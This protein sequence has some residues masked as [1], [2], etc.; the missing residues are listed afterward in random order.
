MKR[1]LTTTVLVTLL[2][3][4]M[5]FAQMGPGG[6]GRGAR[7]YD[8]ATVT[9]VKGT[10]EEVTQPTGKMGRMGT[11]LML[12]SEQGT[13]DVHVGPSSYIASQQF[14]FAKG[15]TIEVVGSKVK[16]NGT[17]ALLARQITKEGKMLSL[18]NEQGFP[19]WSRG[20]RGKR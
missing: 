8:P 4:P 2:A 3:V 18:R 6:K 14:T 12:K 19:L 1:K 10:V 11:H 9:T 15:D 7:H 20:A 17:E 16:M 13:F 5:L